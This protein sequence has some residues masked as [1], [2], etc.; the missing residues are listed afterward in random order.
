MALGTLSLIN[1]AVHSFSLNFEQTLSIV[2]SYYDQLVSAPLDQFVA[3]PL[4]TFLRSAG[5]SIQLPE[6]WKHYF[7]LWA[8]AWGSVI[9]ASVATHQN[10]VLAVLLWVWGMNVGLAASIGAAFLATGTEPVALTAPLWLLALIGVQLL[11]SSALVFA[12][13]RTRSAEDELTYAV[14]KIDTAFKRLIGGVPNL[15]WLRVLVLLAVVVVCIFGFLM[16]KP[17]SAT[18]PATIGPATA[19][20]LLGGLMTWSLWPNVRFPWRHPAWEYASA[21]SSEPD[22]NLV[23]QD[24][25]DSSESTPPTQ[26]SERIPFRVSA[27]TPNEAAA[28]ETVLLLVFLHASEQQALVERLATERDPTTKRRGAA[29]LMSAIEHGARVRVTLSAEGL[30]IDDPD[31]DLTWQGEP[32]SADF[33]LTIPSDT[34]R[35]SFTLKIRAEIDGVPLGRLKLQ[36]AL[37]DKD[38]TAA[39]GKS[40]R[41]KSLQPYNYVFLSYA[42]E[43][44][45]RVLD[46][47]QGL[48]R[49]RIDFF[50]D[51]LTLRTGENWQNA[52]ADEISKADAFLLFWSKASSVSKWVTRET[53]MAL[54]R[55]NS[56][57]E[58]EPDIL[59]FIVDQP[60]PEPP[61]SLNA[62][63]FN[64]KISCVRE[65]HRRLA[66]EPAPTPPPS[67]E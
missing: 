37:K 60:P 6:T 1:L 61:A 53:E 30:I 31:Q 17:A 13:A 58:G 25:G 21:R 47:A 64:D 27:F 14:A 19:Y 16:F 23:Q 40:P 26:P 5:F 24:A 29:P 9:R 36:L 38:A 56:S 45:L 55:H 8:L 39:A 18:A 62:I 57:A 4:E 33:G 41:F 11:G 10:H 3:A 20:L 32:T 34:K 50:H 44:R 51:V 59:P 66:A 42:S 46:V 49:M 67:S 2:V 43:D 48:E 52:I 12:F 22:D 7:V 63:H 15:A 65:L 28:G 54:E 35:T